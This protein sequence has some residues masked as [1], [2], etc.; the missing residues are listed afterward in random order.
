MKIQA[1]EW[2]N[3]IEGKVKAI[4]TVVTAYRCAGI[5]FVLKKNFDTGEESGNHIWVAV[6]AQN[7]LMIRN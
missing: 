3:E 6:V 5:A 7:K 1:H 4:H 2:R